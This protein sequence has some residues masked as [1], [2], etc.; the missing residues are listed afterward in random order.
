[1]I[2]IY[3]TLYHQ[4][5]RE[6]ESSVKR[7]LISIE[8]SAGLPPEDLPPPVREETKRQIRKDRPH[9]V[10]PPPFVPRIYRDDAITPGVVLRVTD[11]RGRPV[12]DGADSFPSL[13]AVR[14]SIIEESKRPFFANDDMAIAVLDTFHIYYKTEDV[15]WKGALYRLHFFRVITADRLFL[16]SVSERLWMW[17]A[18][19]VVLSLA[20]GYILSRKMLNP[21]WDMIKTSQAI[22]IEDIGKRV[23]VPASKDEL[24]ELAITI[25]HMLDRLESGIEQQ[26]KFVS[27]ASH[28][29]R[30][31][32]SVI[33]LA[34]D[35]L[36]RWGREDEA[37]LAENLLTIHSEAKNMTKLLNDLLLLSRSDQNRQKTHME[38]VDMQ[39]LVDDV[40][41]KMAIVAR[42]HK[43]QVLQN[44]PGT[45]FADAGRIRQMLRIFIDNAFKYT[46]DDGAV[47]LSSV[48]EGDTLQVTIKDTGIGIAPEEQSK[49]FERFYR[50]DNART[51]GEGGAGGTGLGL[52]I[53]KWIAKEHRIEIKLKSTLGEGTEIRLSI[54]L[55]KGDE[56]QHETEAEPDGKSET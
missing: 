18:L 17:A 11:R 36:L 41:K 56:S 20:G 35:N 31:P 53:A 50:V 48:L 40:A 25:N 7:A 1:M 52:S 22:K 45:I 8:R 24:Q 37:L 51:K 46:P 38:P 43:F 30:S 32:V 15:T 23:D 19:C 29:L 4:A 5:E 3:Y 16:R 10:E 14:D 26:K 21:I 44:D 54:P 55:Y 9:W 28:E 2:I 39:P 49:V 6:L 13:H 42:D 34:A 47:S 27:D 12:F 33:Y